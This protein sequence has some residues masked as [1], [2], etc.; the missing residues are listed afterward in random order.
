[1]WLID[2]RASRTPRL[3]V[4]NR[5]HFATPEILGGFYRAFPAEW[6]RC[7]CECEAVRRVLSRITLNDELKQTLESYTYLFVV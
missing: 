4:L 3:I 6:Q 5:R 7:E 1:M 2:I